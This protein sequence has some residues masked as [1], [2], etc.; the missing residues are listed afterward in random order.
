MKHV[1]AALGIGSIAL[2][3]LRITL[4][5]CA[6]R[7]GYGAVSPHLSVDGEMKRLMTRIVSLQMG[8]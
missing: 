4:D 7:V 6:W 1:S 8:K 2:V 5:L 3:F